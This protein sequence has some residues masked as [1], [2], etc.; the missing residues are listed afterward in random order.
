MVNKGVSSGSSGAA[1]SSLGA[2]SLGKL[3]AP[4]STGRQLSARSQAYRDSGGRGGYGRY[5]ANRKRRRRGEEEDSTGYPPYETESAE[6]AMLERLYPSGGGDNEER[7]MQLLAGMAQR[8]RPPETTLEKGTGFR[9]AQDPEGWMN[10]MRSMPGYEWNDPAGAFYNSPRMS[11]EATLASQ[12]NNATN[13]WAQLGAYEGIDPDTLRQLNS[14]R[15][16]YGSGRAY[17]GA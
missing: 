8:W 1:Y 9:Y 16:Q 10:K 4:Q 14:R 13:Q 17:Y 5:V 11:P 6:D 12:G 15:S 3:S 2:P 7:L